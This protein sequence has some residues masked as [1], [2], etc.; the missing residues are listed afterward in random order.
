[1]QRVVDF[2]SQLSFVLQSLESEKISGTEKIPNIVLMG[3]GGSGI[4]GDF[5]KVLLR[6]SRIPI[7]VRKRGSLPSFVSAESLIILVTYSG[8]TQE[9]LEA[10]SAAM[11]SGARTLVIT[12]SPELDSFCLR[13]GVR[14][15]QIQDV[16]FPRAA[17]GSMLISVLRELQRLGITNSFDADFSEAIKVLEEVRKQCAPEVPQKSNPAR[18]LAQSLV[19][20][21]PVIYGE[22]EFTDV[23]ALRWKQQFN[24]NAKTHCYCDS[25]PE[26]LH[27]EIE[28]W[29]HLDNGQIRNYVLLLLRDSLH[30]RETGLEAKVEAAKR[31]AEDK[32][33]KVY[34]LWTT[35]SSELA[36]LL[37]LCF[38]GD[39]VSVYLAIARGTDPDPVENIE[40]LKKVS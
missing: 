4:V 12:S 2:P 11:A 21:F 16:G 35:G 27:N 24:E 9:T 14:C 26:L 22:S 10:L 29:H 19:G 1:L 38:V 13:K 34:E 3:M 36:R 15:I 20:S 28:A 23:V 8:K 32:G 18:L 31:L 6:T 40:Q 39:L 7:F 5:V 17:L 25:F 37:S 33:A 30:E